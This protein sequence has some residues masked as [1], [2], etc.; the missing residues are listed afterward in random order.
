MDESNSISYKDALLSKDDRKEEAVPAPVEEDASAQADEP[1][2]APVEEQS[3]EPEPEKE[4]EP[5]DQSNETTPLVEIP[6]SENSDDKPVT[7]EQ[8]TQ[9]EVPIA[10]QVLPSTRANTESESES[11]SEERLNIVQRCIKHLFG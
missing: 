10:Q 5:E 9:E 4:L 7:T 6:L 3:E 11:D 2:S 8:V 1:V